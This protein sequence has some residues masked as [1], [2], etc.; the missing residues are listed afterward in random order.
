[1]PPSSGWAGDGPHSRT[2]Q[3]GAGGGAVGSSGTEG[4]WANMCQSA[5]AS[6]TWYVVEDGLQYPHAT[7]QP[8]QEVLGREPGSANI[9]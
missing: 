3:R 5:S 9:S 2:Y 7:R 8:Q 1:M 4:A 6:T